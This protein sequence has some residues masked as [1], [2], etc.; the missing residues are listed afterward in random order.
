MKD[1]SVVTRASHEEEIKS[2]NLDPI[3]ILVESIN[4]WLGSGEQLSRKVAYDLWK[5]KWSFSLKDMAKT[6]IHSNFL[7]SCQSKPSKWWI[8]LKSTKIS[9]RF[10]LE[11]SSSRDV[12][13]THEKSF[14]ATVTPR[15][16]NSSCFSNNHSK[17]KFT[18]FCSMKF[19]NS[20]QSKVQLRLVACFSRIWPMRIRTSSSWSI[21]TEKE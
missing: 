4:H 9:S 5:W 8:D 20:I 15:I 14:I 10:F 12:L 3:F 19:A 2:R 17:K 1:I 16:E 6:D 18:W 7:D 21:S 13:V 11:T